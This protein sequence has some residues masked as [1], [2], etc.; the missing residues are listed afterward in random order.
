VL[1]SDHWVRAVATR[2]EALAAYDAPRAFDFVVLDD[3]L[4][5]VLAALKERDPGARVVLLASDPATS[6]GATAYAVLRK[7]DQLKDVRE[8]LA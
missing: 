3:S 6:L 7:P 4:A 8:L 1:K 2:E 5:D